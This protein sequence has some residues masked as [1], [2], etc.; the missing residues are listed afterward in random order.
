LTAVS[1]TSRMTAVLFF[2]VFWI[3]ICNCDGLPYS[4]LRC[5]HIVRVREIGS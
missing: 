4:N 1:S 5:G 2:M 3:G